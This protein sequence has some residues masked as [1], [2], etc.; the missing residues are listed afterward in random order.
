M[1]VTKGVV[2]IYSLRA[3]MHKSIDVKLTSIFSPIAQTLIHENILDEYG[4]SKKVLL[5]NSNE[6]LIFRR[7]HTVIGY[8]SFEL[9]DEELILGDVHF[10]SIF[11]NNTLGAYWFVRLL[12]R[13]LKNCSYNQF[14]LAS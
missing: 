12:K 9:V 5:G 7:H 14:L 3:R 1:Y 13:R 11:K 6:L 4:E 2:Y 8:A 10:R